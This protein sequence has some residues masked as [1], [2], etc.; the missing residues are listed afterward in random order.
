MEAHEM[1]VD[2]PKGAFLKT[3]LQQHQIPPAEWNDKGQMSGWELGVGIKWFTV[4]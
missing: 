1:R 4:A 3:T 2:R